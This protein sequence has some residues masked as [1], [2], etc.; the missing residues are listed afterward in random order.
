MLF[1]FICF[2]LHSYLHVFHQQAGKTICKRCTV[3]HHYNLSSNPWIMTCE[4]V[5]PST[6]RYDSH[7]KGDSSL[8][9]NIKTLTTDASLLYKYYYGT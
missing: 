7:I 8:V 4:L 2:Y 3:T 5:L 9:K 6:D 1:F